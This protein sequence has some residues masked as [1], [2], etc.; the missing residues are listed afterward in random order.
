M[1]KILYLGPEGSYSYEVAKE[2]NK[3]LPEFVLEAKQSF[4][5]IHSDIL[6]N[7]D[8]IGILPFENS[9]TSSIYENIEFV[10]DNDINIIGEY[11]LPVELNLIGQKNSDIKNIKN[12]YSHPK[13]LKQCSEF[14]KNFNTIETSST[15]EAQLKILELNNRNFAIGSKPINKNLEI[16]KG[17]IGNFS[18]NKTRFIIVS[19]TKFSLPNSKNNKISFLCKLKHKK[20]SLSTFLKVIS[21][22]NINMTKIES[23]PIP[24]SEFEYIF[25][26]EGVKENGVFNTSEIKELLN[27]NTL[28]NKV[29]GVY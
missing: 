27:Q 24:N 12:I 22:N 3:L 5:S 1:N 2:I 19:K 14:V 6:K 21:N 11:F 7:K 13:A 18:N 9:I 16:K 17:N 8:Y 20:G 26:I 25:L 10:F 23:K 28:E 29:L 4:I 15:S